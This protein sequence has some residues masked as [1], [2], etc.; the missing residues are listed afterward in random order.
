MISLFI[1]A[2]L[3]LVSSFKFLWIQFVVIILLLFAS[4]SIAK[5][6]S[7]G[8]WEAPKNLDFGFC[9]WVGVGWVGWVVCVRLDQSQYVPTISNAPLNECLDPTLCTMLV[10]VL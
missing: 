10:S 7:L 3:L 4:Y 5:F 6:F 2:S 8:Q 1:I 9:V